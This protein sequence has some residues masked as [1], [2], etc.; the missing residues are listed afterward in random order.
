VGWEFSLFQPP[1][2][3]V[4]GIRAHQWPAR[5][6]AHFAQG[7]REQRRARLCAK[8]GN[9]EVLVQELFELVVQRSSFSLPPF[10]L[11]RS[12]N[13]FSSFLGDGLERVTSF[14]R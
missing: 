5:K 3:H 13:R 10:S 12:K 2:E 11:N 6:L 4:R 14:A 8:A 1:L 9:F 7:C